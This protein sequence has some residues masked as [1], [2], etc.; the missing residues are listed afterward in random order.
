MQIG[1]K[2]F[3]VISQEIL[4]NYFFAF[5]M[6]IKHLRLLSQVVLK[7]HECTPPY[8]LS[9]VDSFIYLA[10]VIWAFSFKKQ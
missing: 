8:K 2:D 5:F 7:T 1:Y 9:F 10:H 4:T 3:V 6:T